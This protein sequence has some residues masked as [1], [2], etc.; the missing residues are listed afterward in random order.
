LTIANEP[1]TTSKYYAGYIADDW[2]LNSK[3]TLNLGFRYSLETAFTERYNRFSW[4][5]PNVT[6]PLAAVTGLP[7]LKGGLE[8]PGIDGNPRQAVPTDFYGWDPRF[9]FAYHALKNT[10]V[11]GGVGI[12]HTPSAQQANSNSVTGFG[13][14]TTFTSA[15]NGLVP[16]D[17]LSNPFPGGLVPATGTSQGLLT[18]VGTAVTSI[19]TRAANRVPYSETWNFNIQQQLGKGI[20][21]EVGYVGNHGLFYTTT[22]NSIN[23]DQLQASVQAPPGD[24]GIRGTDRA[25]SGDGVPSVRRKAA[26]PPPFRFFSPI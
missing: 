23:Y 1:A 20:H 14:T 18:S 4:F 2:K 19:F 17:F 9:G 22:N 8:F 3:L 21:V 7:N 26:K 15:A 13:A 12:F 6:S 25:A 24:D 11:R 16:T 10:V 5:D